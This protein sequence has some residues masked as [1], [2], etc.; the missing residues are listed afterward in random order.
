MNHSEHDEARWLAWIED[1]L[2]ASGVLEV[3][4]EMRQDPALSARLHAMRDHR[5]A[6][7]STVEPPLPVELANSV[8]LAR[9]QPSR[10]D[11]L[12]SN[13]GRFRRR[14]HKIKLMR[15]IRVNLRV[16]A[17]L[18]LCAGLLAAILLLVPLDGFRGNDMEPQP[19]VPGGDLL[20]ILTAGSTSVSSEPAVQSSASP[21]PETLD[22]SPEPMA[23]LL[24]TSDD[25]L[26]FL[27][28]LT[29]RCGGTLV[30]NASPDDFKKFGLSASIEG[31]PSGSP[32]DQEALEPTFLQGNPEWA[33]SFDRQFE[34]AD[35]GATWTV[36]VPLSR[37]DAFLAAFDDL[38][39]DE[40][41]LVLLSDHL[42]GDEVNVWMRPA[43]ARAVAASW[44]RT[45]RDTLVRIPVFVEH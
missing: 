3:E 17:M 39:G 43:H 42:L 2:D 12:T 30:R 40:V 10:G 13:L 41:D 34:Y 45:S 5:E 24:P 21:V 15:H 22:A 11:T 26:G 36:S 14:E 4:A 9:V 44:P 6:L 29:Y 18:T 20:D 28:T 7:I 23:M 16:A 31:E 8:D 25:A 35:F 19:H 27:R 32:S 33:P 1:E 37:F 38:Q